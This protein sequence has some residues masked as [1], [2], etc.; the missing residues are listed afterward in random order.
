MSLI[1]E[2]ICSECGTAETILIDKRMVCRRC[3]EIGQ[4]EFDYLEAKNKLIELGEKEGMKN[5]LEF[6]SEILGS[7]FSHSQITFDNKSIIFE[8]GLEKFN[9]ITS[10]IEKR[11]EELKKEIMQD[12]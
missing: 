11:I 9:E 2:D 7:L 3:Y 4:A 8:N 10:K 1:E 6:L 5:E 12:E